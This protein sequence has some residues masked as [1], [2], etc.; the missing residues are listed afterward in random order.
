MPGII[1]S[2]IQK[3]AGHPRKVFLIDGLGACLTAIL[4]LF[5]GTSTN[6]LGIPRPVTV[7]LAAIAGVAAYFSLSRYFYFT[8]NWQPELKFIIIFNLGYCV[9]T[10]GLLVYFFRAITTIGWIYFL[11]EIAVILCLVALEWRVLSQNRQRNPE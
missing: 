11:S 2:W 5:L 10:A 9:V 4:L 6:L 1:R 3:I 8:G 7:C